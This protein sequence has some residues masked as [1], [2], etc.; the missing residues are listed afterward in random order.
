MKLSKNLTLKEAIK[1]NSAIKYR[2][3][4]TPTE[5][6]IEKLKITA[7]KVFQPVRDYFNKPIFVTSMFR[8]EELN[9]RIGGSS[10]SQHVLCEAIDM[11]AD[12]FD[13]E[14]LTNSDIFTYIK[15]NLEFDQLIW[16]FGDNENP[17]WIHVSYREGANRR[18][19]LKAYHDEKGNPKY[20]NI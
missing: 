8:S 11:D 9:K 10:S 15:E 6:Q 7:S 4:N 20:I 17:A 12:V 3:D 13:F 1:S 18:R 2:I 19:C 14:D 16:E 5:E